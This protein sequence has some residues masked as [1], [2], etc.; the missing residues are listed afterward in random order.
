MSI[1]LDGLKSILQLKQ[2]QNKANQLKLL[3]SLMQKMS[4][5]STSASSSYKCENTVNSTIVCVSEIYRKLLNDDCQWYYLQYC[6]QCQTVILLFF[7]QS[8]HYLSYRITNPKDEYC[9]H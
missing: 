4:I 6:S 8:L 5:H 2:A 9:M 3:E 1:F 7:I